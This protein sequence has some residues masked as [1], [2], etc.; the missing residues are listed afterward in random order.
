MIYMQNQYV[1]FKIFYLSDVIS[2]EF[3]ATGKEQKE[4]FGSPLESTM[5]RTDLFLR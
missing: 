5:S 4:S 1:G 2:K 3:F